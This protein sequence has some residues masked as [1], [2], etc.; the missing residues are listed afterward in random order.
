M[1]IVLS[2]ESPKLDR[3]RLFSGVALFLPFG[4]N[5]ERQTRAKRDPGRKRKPSDF[6]WAESSIRQSH[7]FR[8]RVNVAHGGRMF[9]DVEMD[10]SAALVGKQDQHEQHPARQSGD[11]E[12]IH[13]HQRA[14]MIGQKRPPGL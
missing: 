7:R 14:D 13:R 11:R 5:N 12:E 8:C 9:R 2:V 10:D 1:P 3:A 6:H 4:C